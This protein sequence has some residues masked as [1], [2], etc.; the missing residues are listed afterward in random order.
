MHCHINH[1]H[2]EHAKHIILV[3]MIQLPTEHEVIQTNH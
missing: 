2:G 1:G 3:H